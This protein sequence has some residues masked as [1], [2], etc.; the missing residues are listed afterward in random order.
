MIGEEQNLVGPH[1]HDDSDSPEALI[2]TVG[3]SS[4]SLVNDLDQHG[5]SRFV[6][7][8]SAIFSCIVLLYLSYPYSEFSNAYWKVFFLYIFITF[9]VKE[10]GLILLQTIPATID[11]EEFKKNLLESFSE[12]INVHD[13]H[14]WQLNAHKYVSTAHIIFHDQKVNLKI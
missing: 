12:I 9:S 8:V 1:D 7:P 4:E 10:S 5:Y 14:I 13:L 3:P 11:I 2:S 6:D